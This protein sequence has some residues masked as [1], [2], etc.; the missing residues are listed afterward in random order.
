MEI[1]AYKKIINI[2][3]VRRESI[4]TE[5]QSRKFEHKLIAPTELMC[6]TWFVRGELDRMRKDLDDIYLMEEYDLTRR[7]YIALDNYI[8]SLENYYWTLLYDKG[9]IIRGMIN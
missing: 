7:Q 5:I 2:I 8:N 3:R 6:A 1:K 4:V 9:I